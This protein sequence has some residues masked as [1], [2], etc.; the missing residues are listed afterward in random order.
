M[1]KKQESASQ[2]A[3]SNESYF[4]E[5][6]T[7]QD[8]QRQIPAVAV[9]FN[10]EYRG[11]A[12]DLPEEVEAMPIFRE[13]ASG[14][15]QTKLTSPFWE[16]AQPKKNQHC[17]DIGCGVSFLIYPWR[18]W[19]A[20][21]YGQEISTAARDILNARGPQLNSKLFK[22]VSLGAAHQLAYEAKQ[23]DLA[24]ATGVSCY[25]PLDYWAAVLAEAKRVLKP[26]GVFVFDVLDPETPLAENWA[27]LE[28]YLGA[29]VFLEPIADWQKTIHTAG[30]KIVKTLPGEL[31][32]LFK[33][34]F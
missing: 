20:L 28:M 9:R 24:I 8:W 2:G 15:L 23:F 32:Q 4:S 26:G 3:F 16:L 5:L 25:Y 12:F 33:V 21:F 18:E 13:R 14:S 30:G 22:G 11:E 27:I 34:Q 29:E 17:L 19:E 1:A 10:R 7:P 31:F 6:N